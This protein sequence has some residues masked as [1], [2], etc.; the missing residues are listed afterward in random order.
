MASVTY[1]VEGD[2]VVVGGARLTR[3][4][5]L[6]MLRVTEKR[7]PGRYE[8][9]VTGD[10]PR[11]VAWLFTNN[12]KCLWTPALGPDGGWVPLADLKRRDVEMLL[13]GEVV[14]IPYGRQC[15]LAS[16]QPRE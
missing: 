1:S 5:L 13:R 14:D 7:P 16:R 6:E 3:A 8:V 2:I 10:G 9:S 15:V 11:Q 12:M 4:D